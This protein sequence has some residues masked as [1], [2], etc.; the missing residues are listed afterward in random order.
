MP[1]PSTVARM[2]GPEPG[3]EH[4]QTSPGFPRR[5]K[6]IFAWIGGVVVALLLVLPTLGSHREDSSS[7]E[8]DP[9]FCDPALGFTTGYPVDMWAESV[10]GT[11]PLTVAREANLYA[12]ETFQIAVCG[13]QRSRRVGWALV[14][15]I[16]TLLIGLSTR[17]RPDD[18]AGG[19][20]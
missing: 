8:G 18:P 1:A 6:K 17:R 7:Y 20:S 15:A 16:P 13:E 11:D 12:E 10:S 14:V 19:S 4:A 9:F 3:G 2:S 5:E